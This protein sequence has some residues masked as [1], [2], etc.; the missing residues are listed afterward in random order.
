VILAH[1]GFHSDGWKGRRKCR[2][3]CSAAPCVH[4]RPCLG[5]GEV[6]VCG[7]GLVAGEHVGES[8]GGKGVLRSG[9]G[10]AW[11][12]G[13]GMAVVLCKACARRRATGLP[14]YSARF[15]NERE[16]SR[17][18]RAFGAR[19]DGQLA[20]TACEPRLA[21]TPC[22]ARLDAVHDL[23][24]VRSPPRTHGLP[25]R[26]QGPYTGV[27]AARHV[28]RRRWRASERSGARPQRR[29]RHNSFR[30]LVF[31]IMKLQKVPTCLK[32]S[33]K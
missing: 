11:W 32:I 30:D 16:G 6:T 25:R 27:C 19:R 21:Q 18:W 9:G 14:T 33:K 24:V 20:S 2:R 17:R 28:A 4:G 29:R 7:V 23:W 26:V 15:A 10:G 3:R 22:G 1:L 13:T 31:E 8:W 5:S 12:S